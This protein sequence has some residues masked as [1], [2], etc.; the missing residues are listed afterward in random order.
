[1][2]DLVSL[3]DSLQHRIIGSQRQRYPLSRGNP[4]RLRTGYTRITYSD[5]PDSGRA[6]Y[7]P[8]LG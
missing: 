4:F 1:M 8:V 5:E 6:L 7:F 2:G 3:S